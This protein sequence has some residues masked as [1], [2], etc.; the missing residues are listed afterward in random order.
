MPKAEIKPEPPKIE[1]PPHAPETTEP[2]RIDAHKP[3]TSERPVGERFNPD[4]E[5]RLNPY[6]EANQSDHEYYT[7]LVNEKPYR[8]V[9]TLLLKDMLKHESD[10]KL[11]AKQLPQ[12]K[13]FYEKQ[14]PENKARI[15]KALVDVSPYYKDKAFVGEVLREMDR[16]NRK[17][18]A[19][20]PAATTAAPAKMAVA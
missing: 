2:S 18:L 13:E 15:D 19:T 4:V 14:S 20:G 5:R 16:Q 11:I 10:M 6:I 9:R 12:A 8:A 1:P 7:R 3:E 17:Q